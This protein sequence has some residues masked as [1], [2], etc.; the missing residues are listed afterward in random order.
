M[1]H[2]RIRDVGFLLLVLDVASM[3]LRFWN[4]GSLC[5]ILVDGGRTDR[6]TIFETCVMHVSGFNGSG[7]TAV[8]LQ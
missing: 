8:V 4:V 7:P 1:Y 3:D 5:G 6:G 2:V